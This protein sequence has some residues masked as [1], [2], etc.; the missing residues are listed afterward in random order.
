M[1]QK[2]SINTSNNNRNGVNN[3]ELA[4]SCGHGLR[5]I[6]IDHFQHILAHLVFHHTK[7][8]Q[9]GVLK[10]IAATTDIHIQ[11]IRRCSVQNQVNE[12][13]LG[14]HEHRGGV[15]QE[16]S[17]MKTIDPSVEQQS[18]VSSLGLAEKGTRLMKGSQGRE[19][20]LQEI[21][22]YLFPRLL[23]ILGFLDSKLVSSSTMYKEKRSA[24]WSLSD[25]LVLMGK[26]LD[27]STLVGL[28]EEVVAVMKPLVKKR[29]EEMAPVLTSVLVE[30]PS[31]KEFL[32][33]MPLLPEDD[34]LS[35]INQTISNQRSG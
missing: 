7:K 17:H 14:L 30:T 20:G 32:A 26:S 10:F 27:E 23:G 31:V 35:I 34:S 2:Y 9:E 1:L 28:I 15:L 24:L 25:L 8:E 21:A 18:G 6:W 12:L 33:N 3:K 16:F 11:Y 19:E 22:D 4:A 29:P 5:D 13:V